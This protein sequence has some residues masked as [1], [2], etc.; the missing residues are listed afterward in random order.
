MAWRG[1]MP[2]CSLNCL[3]KY[4][5]NYYH[6]IMIDPGKPVARTAVG[7]MRWRSLVFCRASPS[8]V[9]MT[10]GDTDQES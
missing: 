5:N 10:L 9:A 8:P 4:D 6:N 3:A 2:P 7:K 1:L